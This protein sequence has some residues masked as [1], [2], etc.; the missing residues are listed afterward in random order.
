M[1]Q[2]KSVMLDSTQHINVECDIMEKRLKRLNPESL[3]SCFVVDHSSGD[4]LYIRCSP[5]E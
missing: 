3:Q 1:L 4:L 2:T 5:N